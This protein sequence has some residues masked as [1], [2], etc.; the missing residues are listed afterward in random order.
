M[1]AR[2]GV[3]A[4]LVLFLTLGFSNALSDHWKTKNTGGEDDWK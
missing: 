3:A 2:Y 1:K 4:V